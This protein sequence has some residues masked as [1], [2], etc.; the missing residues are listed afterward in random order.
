MGN[1]DEH[2]WARLCGL[3]KIYL[4]VSYMHECMIICAS[5]KNLDL[6]WSLR[7]SFIFMV[8]DELLPSVG[9]RVE[10]LWVHK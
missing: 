6:P 10:L 1:S 7:S 3:L 8:G 5:L 2:M 9:V 4:L